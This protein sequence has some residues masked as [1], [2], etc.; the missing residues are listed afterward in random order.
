MSRFCRSCFSAPSFLIYSQYEHRVPLVENLNLLLPPVL[1]A[2]LHACVWN[3]FATPESLLQPEHTFRFAFFRYPPVLTRKR[4]SGTATY[5]VR[6]QPSRA[7]YLLSRYQ[8]ISK[9]VTVLRILRISLPDFQAVNL[10]YIRTATLC[11]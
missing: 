7:Q 4:Y 11:A 5:V 9:K 10:V 3:L 8:D 6:V 1:H 2:F